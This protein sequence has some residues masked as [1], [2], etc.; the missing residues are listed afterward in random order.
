MSWDEASFLEKLEGTHH[1]PES[2]TFKFIVK[3]EHQLKVES[4]LPGATIKLKPSSGNKYV[5]ITLIREM[6]SSQEVIEVYRQANTIEGI[7]AL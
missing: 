5:S 4:L 1:F 3:P 2:Y 6:K 7:I